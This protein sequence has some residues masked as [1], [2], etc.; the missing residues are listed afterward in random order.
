MSRSKW[1]FPF[2]D[3]SLLKNLNKKQ[4]SV[5]INSITGGRGK[6]NIVCKMARAKVDFR[7]QNPKIEKEIL[8]LLD[9]NKT[10]ERLEADRKKVDPD[11]YKGLGTFFVKKF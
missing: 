10:L 4:F 11:F 9:D 1:K 8:T 2:I 7:F 3:K 5:Q 6:F